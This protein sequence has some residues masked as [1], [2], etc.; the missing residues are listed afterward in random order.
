MLPWG[1]AD[2]VPVP[3]QFGNDIDPITA[4]GMARTHA[5]QL[6]TALKLEMRLGMTADETREADVRTCRAQISDAIH[7]F[8]DMQDAAYDLSEKYWVLLNQAKYKSDDVY[9]E[10]VTSSLPSSARLP[11]REQ[12]LEEDATGGCVDERRAENAVSA[13]A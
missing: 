13:T 1:D 12:V 3:D 10:G 9:E 8:Q 6:A 7:H 11:P 4:G 5:H 2:Q